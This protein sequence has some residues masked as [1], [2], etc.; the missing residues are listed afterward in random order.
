MAV[1]KVA[2]KVQANKK[3]ESEKKGGNELYWVLGIMAGLIVAV[4]VGSQ[5]YHGMNTFKYQGLTFNKVRVGELNFFYYNYMFKDLEG[6]QY[7]YNLYLRHDPRTNNVSIN[8]GEV[9]L[10]KDLFVYI[11][12]NST[13]L[14]KCEDSGIALGG[15]TN[16]ISSNLIPVRAAKPD[17]KEANATNFRYVNCQTNPDNVVILVQQGNETSINKVGNCQIMTIGNCE[18]M[19]AVE[20]FEVQA[21]VDAKARM[22]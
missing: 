3:S 15:L 22:K 7:R 10:T 16:F 12:V 20:K 5:V 19:K 9:V 14:D 4:L 17:E 2:K 1:K 13:G 6:Q 18:I 11:S 21:I 8:G